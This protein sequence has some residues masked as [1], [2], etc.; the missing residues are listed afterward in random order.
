MGRGGMLFVLFVR[1][2]NS[3]NWLMANRSQHLAI[4][5]RGYLLAHSCRPL[6][7][8]ARFD[9]HPLVSFLE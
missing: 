4:L 9:Y 3:K 7:K 6:N 1:C 8:Q 2:L 5:I